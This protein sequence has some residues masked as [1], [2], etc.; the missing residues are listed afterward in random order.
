MTGNH[1]IDATFRAGHLK[2]ALPEVSRARA[3]AFKDALWGRQ[4][5]RVVQHAVKG[6]DEHVAEHRSRPRDTD[7]RDTDPCAGVMD[8]RDSR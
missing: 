6:L 3:Q 1:G 8:L 2:G 4:G 7:P 5:R